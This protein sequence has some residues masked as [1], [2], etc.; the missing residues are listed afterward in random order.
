LPLAM[1]RKGKRCSIALFLGMLAAGVGA[2]GQTCPSAQMYDAGMMDMM[3]YGTIE[4]TCKPDV[5]YVMGMIGH[6]SGA[7]AMC[8]VL[9][10]LTAPGKVAADPEIAG[11]D[12]TSPFDAAPGT[13]CYNVTTSQTSEV[14]SM[15]E[16]LT[17]NGYDSTPAMCSTGSCGRATCEGSLEYD[18]ARTDMMA[19]MMLNYTCDPTADFVSGM[20]G[21]HEGAISMCKVVT[22]AKARGTIIDPEVSQMCDGVVEAQTREIKWFKEWLND[23][24]YPETPAKCASRASAMPSASSTRLTLRRRAASALSPEPL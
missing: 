2:C 20:I 8:E 6:H 7:I 12:K 3:Q 15:K 16:F 17:K 4:Y 24:G 14:N 10:A 18:K 9:Y 11:H 22:D 19:A 5:D 13:M 23:R 1:I 21:H